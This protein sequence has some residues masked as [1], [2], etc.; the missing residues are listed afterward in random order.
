MNIY[1][2]AIPG[3]LPTVKRSALRTTPD[4]VGWEKFIAGDA[5]AYAQRSSWQRRAALRVGP[6]S[7][8]K[9]ETI[10]L[11]TILLVIALILFVVSAAGVPSRI[12]LQSAVPCGLGPCLC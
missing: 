3:V 2:G 1:L 6:P 10:M 12:N 4:V 5:I 9:M 8:P 7:N 11:S